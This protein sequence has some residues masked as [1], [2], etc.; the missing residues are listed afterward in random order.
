MVDLQVYLVKNR[1]N[2]GDEAG[3]EEY[4]DD[5][6]DGD[7]EEEEEYDYEEDEDVILGY[8][9]YADDLEQDDDYDDE[10]EYPEG[11]DDGDEKEDSE[12]YDGDEDEDDEDVQILDFDEQYESV[13]GGTSNQ[14]NRGQ[15]RKCGD[16]L[17][18]SSTPLQEEQEPV[19]VDVAHQY[20]IEHITEEQGPEDPKLFSPD[21]S[22]V[23]DTPCQDQDIVHV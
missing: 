10:Q 13:Y 8:D 16:L 21:H 1:D 18:E 2:N 14:P 17:E 5:G 22:H 3:S 20:E 19:D 7:E 23:Q 6:N 4:Y 12:E 11:D 9:E 15:K